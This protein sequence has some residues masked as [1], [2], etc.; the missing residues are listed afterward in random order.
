MG[1]VGVLAP[2][3]GWGKVVGGLRKLRFIGRERNAFAFTMIAATYN[4]IRL[5]KLEPVTT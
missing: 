3:F 1:T 2:D 4:L 5:A